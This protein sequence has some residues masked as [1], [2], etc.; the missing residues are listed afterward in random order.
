MKQDMF[1]CRV[2]ALYETCHF[3][4]RNRVGRYLHK[5]F[6]L[7][8]KMVGLLELAYCQQQCFLG[9]DFPPCVFLFIRFL[10]HFAIILIFLDAFCKR[11]FNSNII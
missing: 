1:R 7:E 9:Q 3:S 8:I 2:S 4:Y 11:V 5:K 10:L 6:G